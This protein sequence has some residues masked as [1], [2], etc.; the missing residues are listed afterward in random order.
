MRKKESCDR[1]ILKV[2]DMCRRRPPISAQGLMVGYISVAFRVP[3][4]AAENFKR[5]LSSTSENNIEFLPTSQ[6]IYYQHWL[7]YILDVTGLGKTP[8]AVAS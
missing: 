5:T 3:V 4:G 1:N 7:P 2:A 6:A 8:A